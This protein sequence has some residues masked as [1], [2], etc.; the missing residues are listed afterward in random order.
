VSL[1]TRI[2]AVAGLAVAVTVLGAAA[3]VYVAVRSTFNG[4]VRSA[5]S[6]RVRPFLNEARLGPLTEQGEPDRSPDGRG[7][8]RG[9]FGPRPN[10]RRRFGDEFEPSRR[11]RGPLPGTEA[12]GG[13]R[14]YV[15]FV[16]PS[17]A[18][19]R[20]PSQTVPLPVTPRAGEIARTGAGRSFEDADVAGTHVRVLTVGR[21]PRGA[22]QV[23]RPL[24]EVDNVLRRVVVVLT[25]VGAVGAGLAVLLGALVAKTALAP[26]GRFTRRTEALAG[27]PDISERM[28]VT[29]DD[30]LARLARSFNTTLDA[31]E[32]AVQS[33]R[34]LVADASHELRTPIASL[35]ANIQTLEEAHRL[36]PEERAGLRRDIVEELDELTALV[37]DV[38]ELARGARSE[39]ALDEVRLDELVE[40]LVE[41]ARR[42]GGTSARYEVRTEPALVRG[43]PARIARAVSNLLDNARKWSPPDG[44]VD[45]DLRGGTLTVRDRGPG[46][47]A[48]DLPHV[49]ERFYRARE[50]RGMSGSGL[51]LAIVRQT[52]EAHG[53]TAEARNATDCGA[54]LRVRFGDPLD[55]PTEKLRR[56]SYT[57]LTLL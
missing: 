4:E 28:E 8:R 9:R 49:F 16:R 42:R 14:G 39:D 15:Q 2:A 46:F 57:A 33:Q 54:V 51:G 25:V 24:T 43:E 22:V 31:L 29:G 56:S 55:V 19:N 52:A 11:R 38:V 18:V 13:A 6:A 35:R 26:I 34:Q 47:A 20:P 37:G 32:Q 48:E 23:A 21:G 45:V 17:G 50:A 30:E 1:Q 44:Q 41:R 36:P 27:R 7:D 53:G 10:G 5:L 12:F 3:I 40:T